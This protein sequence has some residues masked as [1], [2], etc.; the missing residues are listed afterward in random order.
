MSRPLERPLS[1]EVI[2]YADGACSGNPGPAGLGAI[3]RWDDCEQTLSEYIGDA[4]NNI[5]ELM[6]I[7]RVFEA[8]PD[9]SRP[10]I[11]HSDSSY[12]I[13]LLSKG[14][15][16]K[17]NQELV[18]DVRSAMRKLHDVTL[19]HV[20]GHQGVRLNEVADEL[21]VRAVRERATTGWVLP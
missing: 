4:T 10:L 3:M 13:G 20:R 9:P 6:A 8:M 2:A 12:A 15:N 1:N 16:A 5:A 19:V 21:A 18:R 7:L 17:A 11:L 14:W